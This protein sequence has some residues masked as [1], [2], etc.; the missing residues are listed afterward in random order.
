MCVLCKKASILLRSDTQGFLVVLFDITHTNTNN[1]LRIS[2]ICFPQCLL[3]R[4]RGSKSRI[5]VQVLIFALNRFA[6][7][8]ILRSNK[9]QGIVLKVVYDFT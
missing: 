3:Q 8:H 4:E 2:N 6:M 1:T 9:G 7:L 5:F